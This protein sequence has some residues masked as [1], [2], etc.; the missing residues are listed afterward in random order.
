MKI[1][2]NDPCTCG[3]GYKYKHCCEGK[4][5]TFLTP[6]LLLAVLIVGGVAVAAMIGA[7][8]SGPPAGRVWSPEHGHY[9]NVGQG[10]LANPNRTPVPQPPGQAPPGKVW[11][12]GHGHW[13]DVGQGSLANPNRIAVPQPLGQAPAGKVWSPEHGHWHDAP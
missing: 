4:E 9:H 10:S 1:G 13:H 2:R 5:R 12:P 11:S 3:S 6:T 8:K 7:L